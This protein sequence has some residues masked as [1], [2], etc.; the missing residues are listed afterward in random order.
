MANILGA[1]RKKIVDP[2][3]S[4]N[5]TSSSE[6]EGHCL[7]Q[8]RKGRAKTVHPRQPLP[9]SEKKKKTQAIDCKGKRERSHHWDCKRIW[10]KNVWLPSV[11]VRKREKD[12][13]FF[14]K[15]QGEKGSFGKPGWVG[16]E[17]KKK[18]FVPKEQAREAYFRVR[19]YMQGKRQLAKHVLTGGER[20]ADWKRWSWIQARDHWLFFQLFWGKTGEAHYNLLILEK[21]F[22]IGCSSVGRRYNSIKGERYLFFSGE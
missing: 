14:A 17:V 21:G 16:A 18:E 6:E 4:Q 13:Y 12:L 5:L 15:T 20:E 19:V 2:R 22:H 1:G 10:E 9:K 8:S 11:Q 7:P 3:S